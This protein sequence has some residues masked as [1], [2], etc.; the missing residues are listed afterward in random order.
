M[1]ASWSRTL[2]ACIALFLRVLSPDNLPGFARDTEGVFDGPM[3][4]VAAEDKARAACAYAKVHF[5]LRVP[6]S[7]PQVGQTNI[8]YFAGT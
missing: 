5:L 7:L 6:Y 1:S 3:P 2:N 4:A 8:S